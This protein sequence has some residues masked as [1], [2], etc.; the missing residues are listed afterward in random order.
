MADAEKSHDL[1]YGIDDVPPMA[2]TITLGFQHYLTMF[3]S[4]VAI[5]RTAFG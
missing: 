2:E 4:T 5:R 3:G 1:I